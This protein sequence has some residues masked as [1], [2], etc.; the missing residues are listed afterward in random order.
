MLTKTGQG[1]PLLVHLACLG[2]VDLGQDSVASRHPTRF[3]VTEPAEH[4]ADWRRCLGWNSDPS[5]PLES[6]DAAKTGA[7]LLL[8]RS[9]N[10]PVARPIARTPRQS[11]ENRG[12]SMSL[13]QHPEDST[14]GFYGREL[15]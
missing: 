15:L 14:T 1:P 4:I 10:G 13:R 6:N 7:S 5:A 11:Y 2:D 3:E 12:F 8:T 9:L